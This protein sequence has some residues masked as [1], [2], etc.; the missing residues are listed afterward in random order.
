MGQILMKKKTMP[1]CECGSAFS[2]TGDKDLAGRRCE[3]CAKENFVRWFQNHGELTPDGIPDGSGPR[4]RLGQRERHNNGL[5]MEIKGLRRLRKLYP[6]RAAAYREKNKLD[7]RTA[8][9]DVK[10]ELKVNHG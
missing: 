3:L 4:M 5:K 8:P 1:C 7:W 6:K 9:Y 10:I 2:Y